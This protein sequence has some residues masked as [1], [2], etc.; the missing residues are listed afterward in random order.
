MSTT[1]VTI[2]EYL[3]TVYR[4]DCDYVDGEILERNLG[5]RDHSFWQVEI[6]AYFSARRKQWGA[7][8][9]AEQ[10]IQVAP[11]RFRIP[12]I[13]VT[14]G[15]PSETVFRTPPFI[16]IELLSPEDRISRMNDRFD[17]YLK[18]GVPYVFLVDPRTHKAW[19]CTAGAMVEVTELRTENPE[20]VMPL[21]ELFE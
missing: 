19:R 3:S 16:C 9:F 4:P 11:T 21:A 10:R 2:E 1:A 18:F 7:Y 8:A 17:D 20:M 14:L 13:C 15:W 5:E 12:D 6:G